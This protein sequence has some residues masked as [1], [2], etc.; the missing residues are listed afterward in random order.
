MATKSQV[1]KALNKLEGSIEYDSSY[2]EATAY[3]PKGYVWSANA[4]SQ[5]TVNYGYKGAMKNVWG[6]ILE[7]IN[8][9]CDKAST[10]IDDAWWVD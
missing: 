9:G 8:H 7:A 5:F 2:G 4:C 1:L 6:E 10:D 3:T